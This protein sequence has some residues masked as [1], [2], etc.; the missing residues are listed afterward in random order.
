MWVGLVFIAASVPFIWWW[1]TNPKSFNENDWAWGMPAPVML[2]AFIGG[3]AIGLWSVLSGLR[4]IRDGRGD[5]PI[6]E[7]SGPV[8]PH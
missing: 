7:Q 3:M 6:D 5:E 2:A 8:Q 4:A 1:V